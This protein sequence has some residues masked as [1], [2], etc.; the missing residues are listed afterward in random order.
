MQVGAKSGSNPLLA[1]TLCLTTKKL[2]SMQVIKNISLKD[3]EFWGGGKSNA[4]TLTYD[5]LDKV[6]SLLEDINQGRPWSEEA[7]NDFFWF[8]FDEICE[9]LGIEPED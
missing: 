8:E 1:L 4:D 7:L 6:E 2:K 9:W 3:F 5:Q